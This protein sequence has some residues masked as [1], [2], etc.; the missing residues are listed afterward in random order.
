MP[1]FR[2]SGQSGLPNTLAA[3]YASTS[4]FKLLSLYIETGKTFDIRSAAGTA[5]DSK[6]MTLTG[7]ANG[8]DA[9]FNNGT[10]LARQST[11]TFNP[12]G[13]QAIGGTST[14]T[15]Y[16]LSINNASNITLN[17]AANVSNYLS[18]VNG[19]LITT[20]TNILTCQSTANASMATSTSYVDGPMIHTYAGTSA[21]TKTF[22]VGK[23]VASRASVLTVTQAD[24]TPVTYRAEI[25]NLPASWLPYSNPPSISKVSNVRYLRFTR[26]A[27]SNFVSGQI[28]MYYDLDDG[29]TDMSTLA[30]A[31]DDGGSMW[32]NLGG[33]A[34]TNYSGNITSGIFGSFNSYFAL[35]NP[36]GG[37]NP[38]PIALASFTAAL[39]DKKVDVKWT[40]QS[41]TNNAFFTI[42]RSQDNETFSPIGSVEGAGNTTLVHNYTFTDP[43][44]LSGTSYYRLAQTDFDGRSERFGSAVVNN[45]PGGALSLYPNPSRTGKVTLSGVDRLA[46]SKISVQDITGKIVPSETIVRENGSI[47]LQIDESYSNKG[48][49]FIITAIDGQRILRQ[50]LVI[51]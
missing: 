15:F 18:M 35:A 7:T 36:P 46:Y 8:V 10:F 47:E 45:K 13:A 30:I 41:E 14:T 29:V 9:L 34:T 19:K 16:N 12:S 51:N 11:V 5:G 2:V 28:K 26:Q 23:G 43:S 25:F 37:G 21:I 33:T 22:P 3:S 38:L 4:N 24:I 50:K 42:E 27:V 44:P 1:N 6:T 49:I 48:G 32:T 20:N 31:H 17:R 40:T 39:K